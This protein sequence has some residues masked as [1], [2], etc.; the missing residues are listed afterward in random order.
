MIDVPHHCN[1]QLPTLDVSRRPSIPRDPLPPFPSYRWTESPLT[2]YGLRIRG[3]PTIKY[4]KISR[5]SRRPKLLLCVCSLYSSLKKSMPN[6]HQRYVTNKKNIFHKDIRS[7]KPE[8][9]SVGQRP[10][11]EN[12]TAKNRRCA[13]CSTPRPRAKK[14]TAQEFPALFSRCPPLLSNV[15]RGYPLFHVDY[16]N[17]GHLNQ[18]GSHTTSMTGG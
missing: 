3:T 11:E 14:S 10:A 17:E 13:M 1:A 15:G 5:E 2:W 18:S 16:T 6:G 4:S 7:P 12:T 8:R 9:R